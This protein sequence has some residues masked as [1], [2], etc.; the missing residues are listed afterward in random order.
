MERKKIE[1]PKLNKISVRTLEKIRKDT[2]KY[3]YVKDKNGNA[4]C[5]RCG[6]EFILPKTKHLQD[7]K[8]PKCRKNLKIMHLWRKNGDSSMQWKVIVN[9]LNDSEI[10][11]R[12]IMINRCNGKVQQ[13]QELAREEIN[14]PLGITHYYENPGGKGSWKETRVNFFREWMIGTYRSNLCCLQADVYN[15]KSFINELKKI[16]GLKYIDF[17]DIAEHCF[18]VWYISSLI[19]WVYRRSLLYE[20]LQKAGLSKL[21]ISDCN[22]RNYN[23]KEISY[24]EK[25]KS[26]AKKIGL[27]EDNFRRLKEKQT[28]AFYKILFA[29]PNITDE[30]FELIKEFGF[31]QYSEINKSCHIFQLKRGKTIQYIRKNIV[32][33]SLRVDDY[34]DYLKLLDKLNYPI[35]NR[36]AYPKKFR[37]FKQEIV[38]RYNEY[39]DRINNMTT[40]ERAIAEAKKDKKMYLISKALRKN[41]ELRSWFEGSNGLKVFV[42]ESV[43]ELV[44]SG[45]KLHNCLGNYA[46]R[47][48]DNIS[49]LFFIRRIDE[50]DKEYIAMEY[51]YGKVNQLR[52]DDNVEVKDSKIIS[53]ANALARKLNEINAR[54][55]IIA[56]AIKEVA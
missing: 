55:S 48:V 36:Y 37:N 13:L 3:I 28:L 31:D 14:L 26:L 50:P 16:S 46:D 8:C 18:P 21:V 45:I 53:F 38:K 39:L 20:Q 51:R 5:D 9:A 44:D 2:S 29:I 17:T 41:K 34:I 32:S 30:D 11:F 1:M 4:K 52:L 27:T 10:V 47:I 15:Y 24:D 19:V 40:K 22:D 42:P 7:Y 25:Q 35:D 33:D 43:G 56:T 49:I 12:Y 6:H 23:C 54:E